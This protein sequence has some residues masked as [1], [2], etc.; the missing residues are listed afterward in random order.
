[1]ERLRVILRLLN[2][3][4]F[5]CAALAACGRVDRLAPVAAQPKTPVAR[6]FTSFTPSLQCM[7]GLLTARGRPAVRLSSTPIYDRTKQ[8][9][10]AADDMLINAVNQMNRRSQAF[11]FLDQPLIREG[12]LFE[13]QTI[14]PKLKHRPPTP[15]YYIRG[16]IS[17]L[18]NGVQSGRVN[19]DY[20]PF[21]KPERGL[22]ELGGSVSRSK[23]VVTVDLHLVR[24]PSREVLPGASVSNSM[25]V[26][27]RG[28]G[29]GLTGLVT[30]GTLGLALQ[31]DRLESNGQ[32]ARNLIELGVL[33]LL[34]RFAEV[35]YW[36]C[37]A[38]PETDARRAARAEQAHHARPGTA[39]RR[40][41]A[42]HLAQLDRL[43]G[44]PSARNVSA[45]R[46][47]VA[48][49][50]AIAKFQAEVGLIAS[51]EPDFD[52]LQA[53][54][55]AVAKRNARAHTPVK[56]VP[57]NSGARLKVVTSESTRNVGE[58]IEPPEGYRDIGYF[59]KDL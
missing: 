40:E 53:L 23:S 20:T 3:G 42:K 31:V 1:M 16:A 25:V 10:V 28:F 5:L 55:V 12:S 47:R 36:E 49:S 18:D 56:P 37:L 51:G 13:L 33:E 9:P 29:T 54:R 44:A 59:L 7:D 41:A 39:Q 17:Q 52:T 24:Y 50:R 8:V 30:E 19:L 34:G 45:N 15:D 48:V 22:A 43:P 14:D 21:D 58:A 35:P 4:F 38:R 32:A 27:R 57:T 6:N 11:V 46:D 2:V 26:T